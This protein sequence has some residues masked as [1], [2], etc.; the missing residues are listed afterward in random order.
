VREGRTLVE[1]AQ[2]IPLDLTTVTI[3]SDFA[4]TARDFGG[5]QLIG[6]LPKMAVKPRVPGT[7]RA[8]YDLLRGGLA[9]DEIEA[10][11]E[12]P[13]L[14]LERSSKIARLELAPGLQMKLTDE[15]G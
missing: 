6:L 12:K 2:R 11:P 5:A 3:R 9:A 8:R 14:L 15:Y 1:L 13:I 7:T 10:S 4:R